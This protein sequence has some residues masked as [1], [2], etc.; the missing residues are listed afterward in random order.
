MK[1][2]ILIALI[3]ILPFLI[4]GIIQGAK[5]TSSKNTAIAVEKNANNI[6]LYKFY[7]PLCKDC[8]IQTKEIDKIKPQLP[9]EVFIEE[10]NVSETSDKNQKLLEEYNIMVV[11][12]IVIIDSTGKI[13]KKTSSIINADELMQ[14]I[15]LILREY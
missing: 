11:P 8:L 6:I 15:N 9:K 4:L 12:S 7:S 13:K 5:N 3:F 14:E 1:N 2:K 10:I